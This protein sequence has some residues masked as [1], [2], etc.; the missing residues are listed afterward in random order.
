TSLRRERCLRCL[1]DCIYC[2]RS[3]SGGGWGRT[4]GSWSWG[5]GLGLWRRGFASGRGGCF[6]G[7]RGRDGTWSPEVTTARRNRCAGRLVSCALAGQVFGGL[8]QDFPAA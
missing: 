6:G 8:L 3:R 1:R 4:P 7:R 5:R 2:G